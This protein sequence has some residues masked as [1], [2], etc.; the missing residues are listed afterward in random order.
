MVRNINIIKYFPY[1]KKC[2]YLKKGQ[3]FLLIYG[4]MKNEGGSNSC[5]KGGGGCDTF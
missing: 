1:I 3:K 4:P 2:I 5:I